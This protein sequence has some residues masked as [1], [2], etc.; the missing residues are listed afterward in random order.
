MVA[1]VNRWILENLY[2]IPIGFIALYFGVRSEVKRL[3]QRA[4]VILSLLKQRGI[5]L[6]ADDQDD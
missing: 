6:L 5:D 4:D 1:E 2:M 3:D